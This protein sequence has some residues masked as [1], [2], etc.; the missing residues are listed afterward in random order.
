MKKMVQ[1]HYKIAIKLNINKLY[2]N[3]ASSYMFIKAS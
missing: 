2:Q 3:M 1:S